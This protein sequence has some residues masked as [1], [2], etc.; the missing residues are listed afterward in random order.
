MKVKVQDVMNSLNIVKNLVQC[1][2]RFGTS[3]KV[4]Q[5][6][7]QLN[8]VASQFDDYRVELLKHYAKLGPDGKE[9]VFDPDQPE[10]LEQFN[11]QIQAA[12]QQE[13]DISIS[14][15]TVDELQNVEDF[16]IEPGA[17]ELIDWMIQ[18]AA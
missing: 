2:L 8:N 1:K 5:I 18:E 4:K 10:N 6:V 16:Y 14:K 13:V 7:N 17:I 11:E 3:Y 12:M 15:L 9:Y